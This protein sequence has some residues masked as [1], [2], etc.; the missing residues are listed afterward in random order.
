MAPTSAISSAGTVDWG[1]QTSAFAA[2]LEFIADELRLAIA[3]NEPT[4]KKCDR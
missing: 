2:R 4:I 3:S 1:G